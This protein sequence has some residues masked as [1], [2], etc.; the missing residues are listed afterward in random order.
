M[1]V[2]KI[3]ILSTDIDKQINIPIEL[4]WDLYGREDSID[5]W[6]AKVIEDVIGQPKDFELARFY[7]KAYPNSSETNVI[8]NFNFYSGFSNMFDTAPE[9]KWGLSYNPLGFTNNEIYYTVNSF[10]KSFFK[11][12]FYDS[13]DKTN[14]R[15]YFTIILP[16]NQSADFQAVISEYIPPVNISYPKYVLDFINQKEG[17]F[18][19]WLNSRDFYDLDTFYMSCK[20]FNGKTGQFISMTNKCQGS[21]ILSSNRFNFD[22][23]KYFYYKVKLNYNDFTYQIFDYTSG[24]DVRVGNTQNPI[25]WF[26]Y[27]NP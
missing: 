22:S 9:T 15:V 17:Y 24:T 13:N 6:Q 27:L 16:A 1:N 14:Q 26:E 5:T 25:N 23:K 10:T 11:L 2:N 20:F 4:K 7:N 8:Y 21:N 18:M 19:Y 12:D 3:K